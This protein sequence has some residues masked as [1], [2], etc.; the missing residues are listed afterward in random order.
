[1]ASNERNHR[2]TEIK[3]IKAKL[4]ITEKE[5][6]IAKEFNKY[7]ISVSTT[8][9]S[10]IPLVAKDVCE[11]LFS[12]IYLNFLFKNSKKHARRWN[13]TRPLVAMVLAV[14]LLLMSMI[15]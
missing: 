6:K 2:K 8:F 13:Q 3:A 1:M 11:Y 14:L 4:G 7:F 15:L 5:C 9:A 10:K 12:F